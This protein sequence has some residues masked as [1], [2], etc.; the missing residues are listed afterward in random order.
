[1]SNLD[2]SFLGKFFVFVSM[3]RTARSILISNTGSSGSSTSGI[4]I[5]ISHF[6][7]KISRNKRCLR[8]RSLRSKL[9]LFEF[10]AMIRHHHRP[11]QQG[12]I[13]WDIFASNAHPMAQVMI[14]G[15]S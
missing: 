10:V 7:G 5:G 12:K 11:R 2:S 6:G 14:V 15:T 8:L 4:D 1:M 13:G 9:Y 3:P